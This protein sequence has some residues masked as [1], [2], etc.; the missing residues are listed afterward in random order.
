MHEKQ[1]VT[2]QTEQT[3]DAAIQLNTETLDALLE[4]EQMKTDPSVGQ[5]YEDVD[6]MVEKLLSQE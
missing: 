3:A 1:L 4:V 6:E 5:I 2:T